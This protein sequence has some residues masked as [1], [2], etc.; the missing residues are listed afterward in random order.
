M[1]RSTISMPGF[2]QN[3]PS[4]LN[5][6]TS[7]SGMPSAMPAANRLAMLIEASR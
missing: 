7:A 1:S 2:M 6:Q 3:A 4:P 5:A